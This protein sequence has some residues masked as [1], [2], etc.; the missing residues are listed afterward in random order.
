VQSECDWVEAGHPTVIAFSRARIWDA[1]KIELSLSDGTLRKPR[2]GNV[3]K[4]LVAKVI[5]A[6]LKSRELSEDF[7]NLL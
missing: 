4:S 1:D 6:A 7:K 5:K 3:S 2:Q